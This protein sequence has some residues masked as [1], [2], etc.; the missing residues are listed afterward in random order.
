VKKP[1]L[2]LV[3]DDPGLQALTSALLRL[4]Y[5]VLQ[6]TSVAEARA[7][8]DSENV[9][10][11]L[12]DIGLPDEDGIVLARTMRAKSQHPPIIF[13]TSRQ[14]T[15]DKIRGLDIGGDDYVTKPFDPDELISRINAVLRR[16]NPDFEPAKDRSRLEVGGIRIDLARRQAWN[17]QGEPVSLTRAEFDIVTALANANGRVLSRGVLL[18]AISTS[19]DHD[20]G[21]RTVDALI[22]KIRKKFTDENGGEK[23]IVTVHGFGYRLGAERN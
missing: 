11:A 15:M 1:S 7:L 22:S 12:L 3:E 6:A 14:T 18:D 17:A 23:I 9:D 8:L 13:L 19:P 5:T 20:S 2:L 21:E 4:H 16:T 10:L